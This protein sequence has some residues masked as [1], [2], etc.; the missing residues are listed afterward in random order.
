MICQAHT[1]IFVPVKT[2]PISDAT[3]VGQGLL[4]LGGPCADS[5]RSRLVQSGT[6]VVFAHALVAVKALYLSPK[7]LNASKWAGSLTKHIIR[8]MIPYIPL[9]WGHR[10]RELDSG[11]MKTGLATPT[12]RGS[13]TS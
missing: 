6:A 5:H 11:A 4:C 2:G 9:R 13:V 10:S 1:N 7:F 8:G 12:A 3:G